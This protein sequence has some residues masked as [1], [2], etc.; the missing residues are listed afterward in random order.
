MSIGR[1][2][3]TS[4]QS[5]AAFFSQRYQWPREVSPQP[6]YAAFIGNPV[7]LLTLLLWR[8]QLGSYRRVRIRT[9]VAWTVDTDEC[10]LR[11]NSPPYIGSYGSPFPPTSISTTRSTFK[12]PAA[13]LQSASCRPSSPQMPPPP[14]Y[15]ENL[16][17]VADDRSPATTPVVGTKGSLTDPGSNVRTSRNRTGI[18]SAHPLTQSRLRSKVFLVEARDL[19]EVHQSR[20]KCRLV[21]AS[22]PLNPIPSVYC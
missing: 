10:T 21:L 14:Q 7:W 18:R 22:C 17:S 19:F 20:G 8:S 11:H 6:V 5:L 15:S 4:R 16:A 9:W 1:R 13:S 2:C 12:Y 3:R